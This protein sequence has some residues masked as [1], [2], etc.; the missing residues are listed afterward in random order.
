MRGLHIVAAIALL[1]SITIQN[2]RA[3]DNELTAEEKA[4][5]WQLLF[6]GKDHTGWKC[7]NGK[8]IACPIEDGCLVPYKSGTYLIIHEKQ[9]GDFV[10]KCDVK[11]DK[12]CNSG[13]FFRVGDPLNPVQTGFEM[14]VL[15]GK[16]SSI[17]DFGAVY[18]LAK[19]TKNN[20]KGPGQWD[21]VEITCKGPKIT[22][23]VNG[24][25]VTT[26]NCD[27]YTEPGKGPDG[28]KN[29]FKKAAKDFP[30]KGY[31]GLQDHGSKC[32]YKNIRIREL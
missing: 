27:E 15:T 18:E 17:H 25:T 5:G 23:A 14:Q 16:G 3:A 28:S 13:I 12:A 26:M 1:F 22:V 8:E 6:N 21:S 31:I 2:C 24:E 20:T 4:A 11:M 29:K 9:F 7:N 10:L 30:R 19:P 32:W